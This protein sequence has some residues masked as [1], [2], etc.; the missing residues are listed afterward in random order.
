MPP[1]SHDTSTGF[2]RLFSVTAFTDD[3]LIVNTRQGKVRGARAG[4]TYRWLGIPYAAPPVGQLRYR[5]PQPPLAWDG[6]RDALEFGSVAPQEATKLIPIPVGLKI[7]EDCLSLNVWVPKAA[8]TDGR[9]RPVMVWVHGGAYFIGFSAQPIYNGQALADAGDVIVVTLNYRLGAVGFL[10]FRSFGDADHVFEANLGLRDI[11]AALQWVK[12]NIEN[13]GG[14]ST[15]V[16]LFGE[17]AGGG[18]VTTLMTSPKAKGL[19]HRAIAES[20]PATSVYGPERTAALA[21]AYLDLMG[22]PRDEAKTRLRE[23][24]ADE[25]ASKTTAHLDYVATTW[26]GLVAFAPAIDGDVITDYP[27]NIFRAGKQMRIPL[28]IGTNRDEAALFKLMKSPLMPITG[29]S[30]HKMFEGAAADHPELADA[31]KRITSA[32]VGYPKQAACMKVSRDAGFRMPCTWVAAAHSKVAPTWMYRFDQA[33]PL[34]RLLGIGASHGTELAYVFGTLPAKVTRKTL[35]FLLGG[36][37]QARVISKRMQARWAAF[38]RTG[39]PACES[40]PAWP[41]YDT[42]ARATLLINATDSVANDP[43]ANL[44]QA[45]GEQIVGFK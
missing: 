25:L 32:Y 34:F 36:L 40:Q 33:T 37:P 12:S 28:I 22:I 31:E 5:S 16:T 30:L 21:G 3:N 27:V 8:A 20:A 42:D 11:I 9:K 41:N 45:W 2:T 6:V 29:E 26:P 24:S 7:D 19:F 13:F 14:D 39:S 17:S 43:D 38:G 15:Q 1:L 10:D 18:C 4:N 35:G 44:R 23:L